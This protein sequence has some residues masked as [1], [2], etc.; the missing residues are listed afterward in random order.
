MSCTNCFNGC[1]IVS[2]R[3]VKYSGIDIPELGIQNGDSLSSVEQSITTYLVSVLNGSGVKIDLTGI[4]VCNTVQKYLP[5]CSACTDVSITDISKAL[6]KAACDLQV[7]IDDIVTDVNTINDTLTELNSTYSKVCLTGTIDVNDTHSVLQAVIDNF[8]D[9]KLS[10]NQYVTI[11]E[12]PELIQAYLNSTGSANLIS[13]RMVPYAVV[14]YFGPLTNFGSSGAGLSVT[15]SG[16]N[17]IKVNL[18]NG[19]NGTPDLRGRALTGAINNVPGPT[20]TDPIILPGGNNPNYTL[21]VAYGKNQE[22]LEINQ[23]PL[24]THANTVQTVLTDPGHTHAILGSTTTSGGSGR[25]AVNNVNNTGVAF[26]TEDSGEDGTGITAV[27]TITN[28]SQGE[29]LPHPNI[30]PVIACYYIQYV[31]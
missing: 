21:N 18:C 17:W 20:I 30:Q 4:N 5:A 28:V 25:Y 23:M 8:C 1:E 12:L 19:N 9:L 3:C 13:N 22:A 10:L 11:L 29:N 15:P 27:T 14:P 6:I 26:N 2:D 31:P 16:E 7:Q 24:H